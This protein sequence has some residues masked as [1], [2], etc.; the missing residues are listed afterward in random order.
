MI[1]YID[2]RPHLHKAVFHLET[3]NEFFVLISGYLIMLFTGFN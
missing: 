1:Y 2:R 3:F